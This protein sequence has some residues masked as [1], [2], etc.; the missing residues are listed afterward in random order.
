[1]SKIIARRRHCRN[2]GKSRN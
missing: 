2:S 1:M